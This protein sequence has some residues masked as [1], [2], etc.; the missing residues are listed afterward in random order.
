MRLFDLHCDTLGVAVQTHAPFCKTGGVV[1]AVYG[2]SF[3][4]WVQVFA[5]WLPDRQTE[6]QCRRSAVMML[7]TAHRW[8]QESPQLFSIIKSGRKQLCAQSR[9]QALLAVENGGA[10]GTD[11]SIPDRLFARDVRMITLTWN[12]DNA[13]ASGCYGN[14]DGCLTDAGIKAVHRMEELGMTVDVSHLGE[15]SF[16]HLAD[17]A[18]RPFVATHSDAYAVQPHPR[19]ITDE[20]FGCI[21][22]R[23]GVVGLSFCA[24]HLGKL[25]CDHI[26]RHLAHFLSLGGEDTVCLGTDFDGISLPPLFSGAAF[27][28]ELYEYLLKRYSAT[29]VDKLFYRNAQMFFTQNTDK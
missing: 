2:D 23:G 20:Q 5:A 3:S 10:L 22:D 28:C 15:K 6:E 11:A 16:W 12:G 14:K 27:L 29:V 1:D 7:D 4:P 24:D 18:G 13:W 19:N 17:M 8:E 25:D 21:R 26:E 9:C